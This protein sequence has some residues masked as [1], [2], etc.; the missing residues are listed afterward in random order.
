MRPTGLGIRLA[1]E[2]PYSAWLPMSRDVEEALMSLFSIQTH[3][4]CGQ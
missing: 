3:F 1:E 2:L 4:V